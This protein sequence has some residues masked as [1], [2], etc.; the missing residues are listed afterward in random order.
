[1][2]LTIPGDDPNSTPVKGKVF[3]YFPGFSVHLSTDEP[4]LLGTENKGN[5]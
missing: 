4:G 3:P 2:I 1:M 5:Q